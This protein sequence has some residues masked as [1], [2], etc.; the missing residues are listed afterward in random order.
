MRISLILS[1]IGASFL[2]ALP[3]ADAAQICSCNVYQNGMCYDMVCH[4]NNSGGSSS[5]PRNSTSGNLT[6]TI[7]ANEDEVEPGDTVTFTIRVRNRGSRDIETNVLAELDDDMDFLSASDDGEDDDEEV[8]WEDIEIDAGESETLSLRVRINS[9][10]DDGDE[11]TLKVEAG[12]AE[13]EETIDVED[14]DNDDCY[15][16]NC[17][18]TLSILDD[19]D[20]VRA[21]DTITY[22]IEL[23]NR[24]SNTRNVDVRAFLDSNTTFISASDNGDR[25]N[26]TEVEWNNIRL[27]EDDVKT[28]T[29]RA[30]VRTNL[31][32]GTNLFFR[33]ESEGSYDNETTRVDSYSGG[34]NN[35]CTYYNSYLRQ[36]YQD[37]CDSR[38][39][40]PR[41]N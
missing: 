14:D 10:A 9:R 18:V 34:S 4:D 20:P 37:Y 11:L 19:R 2:L 30:R 5:I 25:R 28:L 21:D 27:Y 41:N 1:A 23:R 7:T 26:S 38:H 12:N 40:S 8:E 3:N 24:S 22:R 16:S 15:G 36:N 35:I 31:S 13:D 32:N 33:A 6:V 29:V 17:D 39:E